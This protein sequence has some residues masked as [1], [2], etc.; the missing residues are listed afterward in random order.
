MARFLKKLGENKLRLFGWTP[1]LATHKDMIECDQQGSVLGPAMTEKD[2]ADLG[3]KVDPLK[4][5]EI[6]ADFRTVGEKTLKKWVE[7]NAA[8]INLMG[9]GIQNLIIAKWQ[10]CF[11]PQKMPE[12]C[13]FM[14]SGESETGEPAREDSK[15][16]PINMDE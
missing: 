4:V 6:G 15:E 14:V 3:F 13:T 5:F 9:L 12:N 8:D 2:K 7:D 16:H 1:A 11:G 10:K